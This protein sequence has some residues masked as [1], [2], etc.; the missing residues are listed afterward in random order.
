MSVPPDDGPV[1]VSACL[2]GEVCR[3]NGTAAPHPAALALLAQG[4]AILV[5]PEVL[6]GLPTPRPAVELQNGRAVDRE[7]RDVTE[8]F[9]IGARKA[10]ESARASGCVLALLKARSPSCGCG[11]VYDGG[12]SGRTVPGDGICAAML[13]AAGL[14]VLT[15]EDLPPGTSATSA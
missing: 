4:R 1:L 7:G 14:R 12:F 3:Y 13:K 6:G 5:C 10:L 15:E 8:P 9:T 2:A 11:Q